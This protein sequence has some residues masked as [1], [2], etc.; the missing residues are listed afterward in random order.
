METKEVNL[1]KYISAEGKAL[2]IALK[3]IR[4]LG[5]S[6]EPTIIDEDELEEPVEEVELKE[7]EEWANR[8][9]LAVGSLIGQ[10]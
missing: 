7:Y 10:H 9:F 1:K 2:K 3:G 5:Y 4:G 6:K 8:N